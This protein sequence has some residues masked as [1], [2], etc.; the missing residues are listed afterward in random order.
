MPTTYNHAL[1][2]L[3]RRS[4]SASELTR[5]LREREHDPEEIASAVE[6]LTAS[7]LL[8]DAKFAAVFARSRLIDRK[9][10]KRRVLTE[11]SRRGVA[12]DIA[13]QAVNAVMED[14]GVDEE[15]QVVLVAERKFRSLARLDRQ[16]AYR[17]LSGFLARRGY[18]GD[19]VRR[20]VA[21]VMKAPQAS[22]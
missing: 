21:R 10:S 3:S 2:A 9:L 15:A 17:R 7:G 14:E 1:D 8:D 19:V 6:R 4:R 13:G 11:L 5:W 20:V 12:R 18:D 22:D 16:V